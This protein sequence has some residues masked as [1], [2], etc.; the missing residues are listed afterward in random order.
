VTSTV[1]HEVVAPL[2]QEAEQ[3]G[4]SSFWVN[5][6]P[7]A[8]G[9]ESLAAAAATTERIR[10][11]VGVIPLD[12]RS[13]GSIEVRLRSLDLPVDR[14][15]L[16]VGAGTDPGGLARVL[17]GLEEL[18]TAGDLTIVVGALGPKMARLAGEE[19]DGV[20]FNWMTPDYAGE[21]GRSVQEAASGAGH[22][23][24]RVAYVRCG[25]SPAADVRMQEE[26]DRYGAIPSYGRHLQR[27]G[28]A[29]IDTYVLGPDAEAMD[30]GLA[31]FEA[32]LDET[33]ARA[34]TPSDELDD[35][36]A[37]LRACAPTTPR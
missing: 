25:L 17:A 34:I 26:L 32:V 19:A 9:L 6:N 1:A 28:A 27:M 16:G 4:Y 37:L 20:L 30:A 18:A 10:L 12:R 24:L 22:V 23:A 5:D 21:M 3:L 29:G 8:D 7:G 2:A 35:L 11:G 13:A 14:L 36:L 15:L 31:R 33:V